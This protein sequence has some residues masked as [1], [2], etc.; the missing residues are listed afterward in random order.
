M[1]HRPTIPQSSKRGIF[2]SYPAAGTSR[3]ESAPSLF[4]IQ[5]NF[6]PSLN[7]MVTRQQSSLPTLCTCTMWDQGNLVKLELIELAVVLA[8]DKLSVFST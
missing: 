1:G 6:I 2:K 8:P 3:T 4:A 5:A 7:Y